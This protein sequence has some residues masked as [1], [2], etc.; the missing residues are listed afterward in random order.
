MQ[1]AD[2]IAAIREGWGWLGCSPHELIAVNGFGNVI[3]RDCEGRYWRICPEEL[4][5]K[6]VA[7]SEREYFT[8]CSNDDFIR[9]W[10]MDRLCLIAEKAL[11]ALS[12]GRSYCL[13]LPAVFGHPYA[14]ENMGIIA[15]DELVLVSGSLAYQIKDRPDGTGLE[16][17][18]SD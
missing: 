2:L 13:K 14:P 4:Q 3:F 12:N 8:L 16:I 9:D 6:V 18:I 17:R 15:T 5:C 1:E 11:G 7:M 10:Q